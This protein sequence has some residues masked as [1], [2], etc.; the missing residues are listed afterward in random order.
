MLLTRI[1]PSAACFSDFSVSSARVPG[2]EQIAPFQKIFQKT[3]DGKFAM[4]VIIYGSTP[5][6]PAPI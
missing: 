5:S 4:L 3:R 2:P 1:W 6:S